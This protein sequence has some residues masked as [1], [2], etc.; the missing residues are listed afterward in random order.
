MENES[1]RTTVIIRVGA[2]F[3]SWIERYWFLEEENTEDEMKKILSVIEKLSPITLKNIH[4][5]RNYE[6]VTLHCI[7]H[8]KDERK[9][10]IAK[11]VPKWRC[12]YS[13]CTCS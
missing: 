10:S 7:E 12:R 1:H 9:K 6:H 2:F 13:T 3:K 8:A 5:V 4:D 11:L